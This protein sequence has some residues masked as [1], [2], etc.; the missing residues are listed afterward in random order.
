MGSS[1]HCL[2]NGRLELVEEHTELLDVPARVLF[3]FAKQHE[4]I[5]IDL[6]E[7]DDDFAV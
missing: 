3:A 5:G 2:L 6:S 7:C 1:T 4:E